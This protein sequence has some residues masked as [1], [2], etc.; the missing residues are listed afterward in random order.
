MQKYCAACGSLREPL[1]LSCRGCHQL[2]YA[3]E[4]EELAGKARAQEAAVDTPGASALWRQVL[5]LLPPESAQATVVRE[6]IAKLNAASQGAPQQGAP[7]QGAPQQ[8]A[9]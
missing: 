5:A 1:E 9:G 4:M 3:Q 2:V 6:R 7:Q 8:I